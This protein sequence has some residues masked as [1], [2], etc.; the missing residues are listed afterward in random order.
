[1]FQRPLIVVVLKASQRRIEF[2]DRVEILTIRMKSQMT[3]TGAR[4]ELSER[5]FVRR[6]LSTRTVILV[7]HYLVHAE[8]SDEGIPFSAIEDDAMCVWTFLLFFRSG[9]FVLLN[10]CG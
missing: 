8:V 4:L 9:A 6:Q 1:M 5:L 10:V 7:D 2:I 3:R